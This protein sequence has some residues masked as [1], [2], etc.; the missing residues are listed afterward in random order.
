MLAIVIPYYKL[1]FFEATLQSLASQTDKRFKVYIGDDASPENPIDI[2]GNYKGKFDFIYHRFETNLGGVSLTQHWERCITL[3]YD[4]EWLM[5]LGD[6]DV[7]GDNVVEEFYKQYPVFYSNVNVVRF[8]S[9]LIDY[10]LGKISEVFTH[11]V[12]ESSSEFFQRK[13]KEKTRSS[14]SEY[15]FSKSSYL[16]CKFCD[17]PLAWHSDDMAWIEFSQ[18]KQIYSINEAQMQIGFSNLSISG[19]NDNLDSKYSASLAFYKNI[20]KKYSQIFSKKERLEILMKYEI[21]IKQSRKLY[22]EEWLF[23]ISHYFRNFSIIPF[24][25][26]CRRIL[27]AYR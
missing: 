22:R 6:D 25:K 12:W 19:R 1:T 17:Y 7:L 24:A 16:K 9:K 4:E 2:L 27:I 26:L 18:D 11:P 23:L 13:L 8:S 5:I 10:S 15:V 3:S 20:L 14:L 21:L